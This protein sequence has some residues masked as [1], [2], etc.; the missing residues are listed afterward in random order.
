MEQQELERLA[1]NLRV[2]DALLDI[3]ASLDPIPVVVFKGPILT[4]MIYGDLRKRASADNDIWVSAPAVYQALDRL[5]DF[6]YRPLRELNPRSAIRRVGQVALFHP[7]AR[8]P[9]VDLHAEPFSGRFF[10]VNE[11]LLR[12]HL[13]DFT[14]HGCT[15]QTFDRPLAFVHMVAHF[16]QHHCEEALLTDI[17]EAWRSWSHEPAVRIA[18]FKLA[19]K[20][21]TVPALLL[22]LRLIELRLPRHEGTLSPTI[23]V[24]VIPM[25]ARVR[26]KTALRLLGGA[27]RP[28]ALLSQFLALF[29]VAPH[30]LPLGMVRA[31]LLEQDDLASRYGPGRREALLF[32]H[33]RRKLTG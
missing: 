13:V 19:P 12:S 24:T 18:I 26:V 30:R 10:S 17:G 8:V 2:E 7:D 3:L 23:P 21:C 20:T 5:L 4:R 31:L 33:L 6:G 25:W 28:N 27:R 15:V 16:I 32:Q 1:T 9:S 22:V 29:V 11:Q 14:L